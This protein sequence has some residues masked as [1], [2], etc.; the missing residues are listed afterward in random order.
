MEPINQ[1]EIVLVNLDPTVGNEMKKTRPCVVI[2]PKEMNK[3]LKTII[4]APMTTTSKPYPT[5]LEVLHNG[6][7][8]WI[9]LDQIRTIDRTR[10][11]KILGKLSE[12]EVKKVKRIIKE[13][14]V[15]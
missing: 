15:D 2:S 3:Y 6:M 13:M 14:F 12:K 5:R 4:V 10:I 1:Y 11:V 9:V 8:G 7:Q